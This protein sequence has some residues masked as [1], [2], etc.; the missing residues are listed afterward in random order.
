MSAVRQL[1]EMAGFDMRRYHEEAFAPPPAKA[2]KPIAEAPEQVTHLVAF[3][4]SGK[5]VRVT[6]GET[7]HAAAG[8]LGL[9]IPKAC[10]M[11]ICGTCLVL[12][13]AGEVVLEHKGGISDE[14]LA[15]GYVLSC[16]STPKGDV[17][18]DY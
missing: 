3:S 7:L 9:H 16:C 13:S 8:K 4:R 10:G 1:L 15:Q 14:E 5:S 17:T 6:P 12:K 11:G 18:I 2:C